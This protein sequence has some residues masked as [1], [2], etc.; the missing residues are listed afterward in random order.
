MKRSST[1]QA[2]LPVE[3]LA[4]ECRPVPISLEQTSS[5]EKINEKSKKNF[6]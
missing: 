4:N 1:V 2:L 3:D 6:I 5:S